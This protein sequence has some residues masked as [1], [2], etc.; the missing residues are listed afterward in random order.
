MSVLRPYGTDHYLVVEGKKGGDEDEARWIPNDERERRD[1]DLNRIPPS[2]TAM[3]RTD[4]FPFATP[5]FPIYSAAFTSDREVVFGGGG[6]ASRSGVKNKLVS[7]V[8]PSFPRCLSQL[9][10][11]LSEQILSSQTELLVFLAPPVQK[12]CR[13]DPVKKNITTL[14][15]YELAAEEDTPMTMAIS[16]TVGPFTLV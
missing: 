6:G 13:I 12:L 16:P 2:L 14:S 7:P 15:E 8:P 4:H 11:L 3:T 9:V 10:L 5:S 1:L